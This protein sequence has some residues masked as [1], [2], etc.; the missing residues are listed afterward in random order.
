[1]FTYVFDTSFKIGVTALN[2]SLT[3]IY[4]IKEFF[5]G[6]LG[7]YIENLVTSEKD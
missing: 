6:Y 4:I 7:F 1:M 3:M 5:F 2:G